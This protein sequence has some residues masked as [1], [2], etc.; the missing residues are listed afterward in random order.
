MPQ[1][2]PWGIRVALVA[3]RQ[4][5]TLT[6]ARIESRINLRK[7]QKPRRIKEFL[8]KACNVKAKSGREKGTRF[9]PRDFCLFFVL[10]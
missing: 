10:F 5:F 3:P 8:R 7:L 1:G 4:I 2:M 6:S 9:F